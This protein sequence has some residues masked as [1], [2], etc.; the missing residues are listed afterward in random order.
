MVACSLNHDHASRTTQL[1]IDTLEQTPRHSHCQ[2]I[3]QGRGQ[4]CMIA[5]FRFCMALARSIDASPVPHLGSPMAARMSRGGALGSNLTLMGFRDI[6]AC[7]W[8]TFLSPKNLQEMPR[9]TDHKFVSLSVLAP[10]FASFR[11]SSFPLR[12]PLSFRAVRLDHVINEP[13]H[14]CRVRRWN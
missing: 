8:P 3:T 7:S 11:P 9:R 14:R 6:Y 2:N 13:L 10:I 4:L 5:R 1:S 12:F